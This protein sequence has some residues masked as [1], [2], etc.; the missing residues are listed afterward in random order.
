MAQIIN[1]SIDLTKIDKSKI[2]T[3]DKSG[4]PFKNGA[5]YY[6]IQVVINDEAD[7]YGN[8]AAIRDNQTQAEREAG[9]KPTYLGNGKTVWKQ[10]PAPA[11]SAAKNAPAPSGGV[12]LGS[13][14][15]F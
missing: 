15:P 14:L 13:D 11:P 12:D 3:T 6:N 1:A 5:K 4:Q 10:A 9:A 2:V 8:D 7:Q